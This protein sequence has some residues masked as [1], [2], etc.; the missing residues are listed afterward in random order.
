MPRKAKKKTI[1]IP[2]A[3]KRTIGTEDRQP[4]Y[5]VELVKKFIAAIGG[6][7]A[8][9]M[10]MAEEFMNAQPKSMTRHRYIEMIMRGM[11]FTDDRFGAEPDDLSG[12]TDAEVKSAL[13]KLLEEKDE[14]AKAGPDT[15]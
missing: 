15:P 1:P 11:R 2:E 12:M 14:P 5:M 8:L 6:I 7:D 13:K 4:A 10:A 3:V 9:V